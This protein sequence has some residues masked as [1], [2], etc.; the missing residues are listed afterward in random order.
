MKWVDKRQADKVEVCFGASMVDKKRTGAVVT[1]TRV[2][3]TKRGRGVRGGGEGIRDSTRLD[4][5]A[6][7]SRHDRPPDAVSQDRRSLSGRKRHKHYDC[8]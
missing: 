2:Y 6:P 3:E 7:R 4:R 5:H 1:R 8:W